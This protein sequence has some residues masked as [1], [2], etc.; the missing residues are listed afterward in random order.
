MEELAWSQTAP[1]LKF[2]SDYNELTQ[3]LPAIRV[4]SAGASLRVNI[5]GAFIVE[6][7]YAI[8]FQRP[9]RDPFNHS[10]YADANRI[11]RGVF[12]LLLYPGW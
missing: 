5:L 12:G 6:G 9:L 8:P 2:T 4:F 11:S 10:S 7:Y 1:T 3:V